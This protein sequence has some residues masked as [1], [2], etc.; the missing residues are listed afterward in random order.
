MCWTAR[1]ATV[2]TW[3]YICMR[4][5]IIFLSILFAVVTHEQEVIATVFQ[6]ALC[7]RALNTAV[8]PVTSD[9]RPPIWLEVLRCL[10]DSSSS[11]GW[12]PSHA[13]GEG[14]AQ[15]EPLA[16]AAA[17]AVWIGGD[18]SGAGRSGERR[19]REAWIRWYGAT[20]GSLIPAGEV[21]SFGN[22]LVLSSTTGGG[23]AGAGAGAGAGGVNVRTGVGGAARTIQPE[24]WENWGRSPLEAAWNFP[25]GWMG[26]GG[27]GGGSEK[28]KGYDARDEALPAIVLPPFAS[29]LRVVLRG[30]A[31]CPEGLLEAYL[32]RMAREVYLPCQFNGASG[33]MA[34]Q[35]LGA[36]MEAEAGV[37]SAGRARK[38][39]AVMAVGAGFGGEVVKSELGVEAVKA[40]TEPCGEAVVVTG[41]GSSESVAGT[42]SARQR[43]VKEFFREELLRFGSGEAAAAPVGGPLTWLWPLEAV[44]AACGKAGPFGGVAR[45]HRRRSGVGPE[46][47]SGDPT[48][49]VAL[50]AP[51]SALARALCTVPHDLLCGAR[52]FDRGGGQPPPAISTLRAFAARA[53]DLTARALATPPCRHWSVARRL[54]L[55]LGLLY[56]ALAKPAPRTPL[57][58]AA[59][60][61]APARAGK[62]RETAGNTGPNGEAA[63][64]L[65]AIESLVSIALG[66]GEDG[67]GGGVGDEF[68]PRAAGTTGAAP[69]SKTLLTSACRALRPLETGSCAA[70]DDFAEALRGAGAW[71]AATAFFGP[72]MR[73]A[74]PMTQTH[75]QAVAA[76]MQTPALGQTPR[77]VSPSSPSPPQPAPPPLSPQASLKQHQHQHHR[78]SSPGAVPAEDQPVGGNQADGQSTADVLV[79]GQQ[80]C[81]AGGHERA[82]DTPQAEAAAGGWK[83][84]ASQQQD[85]PSRQSKKIRLSSNSVE[86]KSP[87][88]PARRTLPPRSSKHVHE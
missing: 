59:A 3:F 79:G 45:A 1:F 65:F 30:G 74:T 24:T 16:V 9:V 71:R 43:V 52:R 88:R 2:L 66:L 48:A 12:S 83:F 6:P 18:G 76:E 26:A 84:P 44:V 7:S 75:A 23:F 60:A 70:A 68:S 33:E 57:D 51:P 27:F 58:A 42:A 47:Q 41:E 13:N 17:A 22:W 25:G 86:R 69:G 37:D 10:C 82:V 38:N 15:Q 14:A 78:L 87:P 19:T 63:A 50:D 77:L 81:T 55:G 11:S 21:G 73:R 8:A 54:L 20:L 56:H 4:T 36:L 31:S 5:L 67:G 85:V 32:R 46:G 28:E 80:P 62:A 72:R 53:V 64:A 34:R 40:E 29:W 35:W 39:Y 49:Q 61:S